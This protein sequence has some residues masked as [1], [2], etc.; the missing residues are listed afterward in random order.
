MHNYV[1]AEEL[2]RAANT[3]AKTCGLHYPK[4]RASL[5]EIFKNWSESGD[6]HGSTT[7]IDRMKGPNDNDDEDVDFYPEDSCLATNITLSRRWH[8]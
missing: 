4:C 2:G 3:T 8:E 6:K 1:E 7:S 5:F